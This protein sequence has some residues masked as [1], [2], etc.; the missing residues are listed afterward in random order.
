MY[1]CFLSFFLF[2]ASFSAF[3]Q[4]SLSK[5]SQSSFYTYIYP[6]TD[7]EVK[8]LY[9]SRQLNQALLKNPI[10]SFLTIKNSQP[11]LPQGNYV[12]VHVEK[13]KLHYDLIENR[14]AYVTLLGCFMVVMN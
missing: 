9:L 5:T 6:I 2:L 12:K 8:S 3:A 4:K 10:D 11:I 1:K 7:Q 13:N 14:S